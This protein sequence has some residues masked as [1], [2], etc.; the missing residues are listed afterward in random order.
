MLQGLFQGVPGGFWAPISGSL[1]VC[2]IIEKRWF[3]LYFQAWA[4]AKRG[5]GHLGGCLGAFMGASKNI[6]SVSGRARHVLG[7]PWV[8]LG[9]A[10]GTFWSASMGPEVF[11]GL[12][13][14]VLGRFWAAICGSLA[15]YEII[16][17]R[18]FLLYY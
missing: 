9:G 16:Q 14:V 11:Q 5:S 8:T 7:V 18:C 3:L 1:A 10:R 12:L 13:Q 17:K 2:K 15:V 6:T 4:G